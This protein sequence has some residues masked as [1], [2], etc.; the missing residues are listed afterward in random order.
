MSSRNSAA[1]ETNGTVVVLVVSPVKSIMND[2][3]KE[4]RE[5]RIPSVIL[6]KT[7]DVLQSF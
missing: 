5:F 4:M 3:I 2:Q 6:T 1:K 7:D